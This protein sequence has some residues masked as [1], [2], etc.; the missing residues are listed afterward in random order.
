MV[1]SV[2]LGFIHIDKQSSQII[3]IGRCT[4]LVID[5]TDSIMGLA[6]IQH[7]LDEI[8]TV[9]AEH[10][11]NADNEI[12]LQRLAHCQ[13][14]FQLRLTV[15]IQRFIALT[16]RL[17]RFCSLTVEHIVR[18]DIG[19]L[20]VQPLADICNILGSASI[21]C[22]NFRHFVVILCHVHSRPCRTVDHSV[23]IHFRDNF[24]N[25]IFIRNIQCNIRS[26]R[27]RRTICHAAV[28]FLNVRT[29]T[30]MT[31]LQQFVHDIM[32]Q[33][34]ANACYKN[35]IPTPPQAFSGYL[36]FFT[37]SHTGLPK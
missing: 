25:S 37:L 28:V 10:P 32:S 1:I 29:H 20:A 17:P 36:S 14:T 31:T 27:Y 22:T 5:H 21:D 13:L 12:L 33:L 34:T 6:Y 7:G 3:C 18:A 4:D 35:L 16:I 9:Q 2:L 26:L 11:C 24:L 19:H 23:R 15:H 30:F 8:F